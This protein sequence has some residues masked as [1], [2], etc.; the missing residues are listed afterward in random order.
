LIQPLVRS[1]TRRRGWTAKPWPGFGPDTMST[2]TAAFV[3]GIGNGSAGV[4]LVQPEV[5][6]GGGDPFVPAQQCREHGSVLG[7]GWG[8]DGRNQ[9]SGGVDEDVTLDA[10][11]FFGAVKTAWPGHRRRF[12]R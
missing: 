9:H 10:I 1:T 3:G 2:P 4:A 8:D 11:D 5:G 7:V 6:D 12:D